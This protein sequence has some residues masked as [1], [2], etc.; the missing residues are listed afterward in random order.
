MLIKFSFENFLSFKDRGEL[1]FQAG[2]IKEHNDNLYTPLN[3]GD[4]TL[5]KSIGIYGANSSG[6]SNVIKALA[7]MRDFVVNSS[8]ESHAMESIKV[9]PFRLSTT[10]ENKKSLFEVILLL[11]GIR[12]RY[13][14][15]VTSHHVME[16]W[17]FKTEKRKDEQL[18]IRAGQEIRID[19]R[20]SSEDKMKAE[21]LT[22]MTKP[23]SLFISVLTHFNIPSS[24]P[25]TKWFSE[26][27]IA[28][29]SDH[30]SLINFSAKLLSDLNYRKWINDI[31]KFSQLGIESL[32][33]KLNEISRKSSYSAEFLSSVFQE[34]LKDYKVITRH[35]KY[36]ENFNFAA[37]VFFDLLENESLGTQKYFALLGPILL[38][39]RERRLILIDEIDTRFHF[40]LFENLLTLF[41]SYKYNNNGAQLVFTSHNPHPLK[42]GIRRDQMYFIEKNQYGASTLGSLYKT[43]PKVRNDASF[44]KDY[45]QGKYTQTPPSL[46]T[47]LDLF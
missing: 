15:S 43:N 4:I 23:N 17:L 10:A 3:N 27:I 29:D 25:I 26:I 9:Q 36:D 41:N 12:Y 18:F 32:D 47:Q 28:Q 14:F 39:I 5:L 42:K 1:D 38:A 35:I 13:G 45:L 21:L 20:F 30:I 46:G 24:F 37:S 19:R 22:Q 11:D 2:T 40:I 31:I 33:A 8:K 6:K 34:E 7:F 44:D 16:E